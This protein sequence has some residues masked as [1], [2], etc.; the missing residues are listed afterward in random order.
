MKKPSIF[1]TVALIFLAA[2]MVGCRTPERLERLER[3][4]AELK[5]QLR[6]QEESRQFDL[7]AK[8]S[9]RAKQFYDGFD[10]PN[11]GFRV[12][13]P[14]SW[15]SNHYN[16]QLNKCFVLIEEHV[17]LH[18][19]WFKNVWI[20]DAFENSEHAHVELNLELQGRL[21]VTGEL[22]GPLNLCKVEGIIC[23]SSADFYSRIKPLMSN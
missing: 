17:L 14:A 9:A 21:A 7:Q 4:Q 12:R 5:A 16:R 6:K 20:Y 11:T 13:T 23:E 10:L 1:G 18:G 19:K 22:A 3:E 2:F 15:Y 8:C